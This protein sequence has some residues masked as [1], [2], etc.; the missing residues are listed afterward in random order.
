MVTLNNKLYTTIYIIYC[1]HICVYCIHIQV[2]VYCIRMCTTNIRTKSFVRSVLHYWTTQQN[3][4]GICQQNYN[5]NAKINKLNI[6]ISAIIN[7]IDGNN[8]CDFRAIFTS[9]LPLLVTWP[10]EKEDALPKKKTKYAPVFR[11]RKSFTH[12]VTVSNAFW[13]VNV[14]YSNVFIG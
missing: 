2:C 11:C 4:G 10:Q 1:I 6:H 9:L 13:L 14:K 7:V 12:W 5:Y 8:T 3:T